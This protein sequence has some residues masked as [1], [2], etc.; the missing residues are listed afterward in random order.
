MVQANTRYAGTILCPAAH[1]GFGLN[2]AGNIL[3]SPAE[4]SYTRD[5][6]TGATKEP[7]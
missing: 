6:L 1:I 4:P 5:L 7:C 3:Y 2:R